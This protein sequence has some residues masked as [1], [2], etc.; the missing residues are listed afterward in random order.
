MWHRPGRSLSTARP[1]TPAAWWPPSCGAGARSS[2]FPGA[3]RRSSRSWRR[4]SG[5]RTR[6]WRGST[7]RP[8]YASSW[9]PARRVISC[10]G[11]FVQHGE[12][13]LAAA[14][15]TGTH[16][17][18]TTGEQPFMRTVFERYGATAEGTGAALVTAMGFDYVPG[19]LIASLTAGAGPVDEVVLAYWV[20]GFGP[21]R[22]DRAVG[23]RDHVGRRRRVARR[24]ATAGFAEGGQGH[25]GLRRGDRRP[26]DGA[27]P[28]GRAHHGS[29]AR[30]HPAG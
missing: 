10:A 29:E 14:A 12:P 2:C 9:S 23:A 24:R 16:Y 4:R 18:D 8:A 21:T 6:R 3:T 28:R 22:G 11:P 27:L 17:I 25:L 7:T 15:E 1:D 5:A 26:A 20:K 19:D 13:V 30:G